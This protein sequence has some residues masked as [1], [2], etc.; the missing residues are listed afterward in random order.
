MPAVVDTSNVTTARLSCLRGAGVR[1]VIRYY[2]RDT[3]NPA[4]VVRGPEARAIASAGMKLGAV[5]EGRLGDR[6]AGFSEELGFADARHSRTYAFNE[7]QQPATTAIYF[8]VDFDASTA[9]VNNNIIP[10]FRGVGRAFAETNGLPTYR[11]GVYGSGRVCRALL[12]AGLAELAWLAQ[13]TGWA[14]HAAFLN[15]RDWVLN[16][17]MPQTL[18]SLDCDPDETNPQRPDFGDFVPGFGAQPS[19]DAMVVNASSGLRLRAGPGTQ[20]DV[21]RVLPLGTRVMAGV[22]SDGWVMVDVN[23]DGTSDGFVFAAFLTPAA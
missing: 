4:K 22:R 17:L 8:G 21:I 15:S 10:Y 12:T 2:A 16:Q 5:H 6:I 18:C 20:F 11:V 9:Q 19:G 23:G 1:T 14:G 3:R 7:I 13:S